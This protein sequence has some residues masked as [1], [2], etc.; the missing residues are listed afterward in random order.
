M[1]TEVQAQNPQLDYLKWGAVFLLIIVAILGNQYLSQYSA[2]LR[3][4]GVVVAVVAAAFIALQTMKG[5]TAFDFAKEA[6]IEVRKVVWPTRQETLQ[7]TLIVA[8]FVVILSLFL[9]GIDSLLVW[10]LGLVV[11]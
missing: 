1:T 11:G 8:V 3:A 10:G 5:R 9:W 6:H 7:T 2:L 4:G